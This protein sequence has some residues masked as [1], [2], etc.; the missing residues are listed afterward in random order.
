MTAKKTR[1]KIYWVVQERQYL[2]GWK[3]HS[4]YSTKKA[5]DAAK[6]LLE[7]ASPL[8][9]KGYKVDRVEKVS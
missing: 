4:L 3:A 9:Y 1:D 8:S 5:A 2:F 6:A 7:S